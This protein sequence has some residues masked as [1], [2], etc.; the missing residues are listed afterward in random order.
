M[1]MVFVV[2]RGDDLFCQDEW[3]QHEQNWPAQ[4]WRGYDLREEAELA[5][6]SV[7]DEFMPYVAEVSD[8]LPTIH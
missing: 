1:D 3:N 6:M 4:G 8:N 7:P 5:S 2:R